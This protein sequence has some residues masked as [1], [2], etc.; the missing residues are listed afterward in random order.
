MDGAGHP[1]APRTGLGTSG[2]GDVLAGAVGGAGALV[3]MPPQAACWATL[4]HRRAA[5][6][7]SEMFAPIGYLA[8]QLAD[9]LPLALAE[10][11][12][13]RGEPMAGT[14]RTGTP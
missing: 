9:E 14:R 1:P 6:R 2:A 7:L 4:C 11:S 12:E 13:P 5:A 8:R 3:T 10:L